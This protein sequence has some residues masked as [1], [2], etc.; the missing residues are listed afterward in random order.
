MKQKKK[1]NTK[2]EAAWAP[3]KPSKQSPKPANSNLKLQPQRAF[4]K[5]NC[6]YFPGGGGGGRPPGHPRKNVDS[7]LFPNENL[8]K[9]RDWSYRF[10]WG[11]QPP[12]PGKAASMFTLRQPHTPRENSLNVCVYLD[13]T[14]FSSLIIVL[15]VFW[16]ESP[17]G[18]LLG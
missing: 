4:S 8:K 15:S 9:N 17:P 18:F 16:E 1:N 6:R 3:K 2:H 10:G 13:F 11:R 14:V 5:F 7:L 12:P